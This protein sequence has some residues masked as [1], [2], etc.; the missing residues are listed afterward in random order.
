MFS[1]RQQ[2]T[3]LDATN[4]AVDKSESATR[5]EDGSEQHEKRG[6]TFQREQGGA[7]DGLWLYMSGVQFVTA[8]GHHHGVGPVGFF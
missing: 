1:H 3:G 7:V 4:S 2:L 5:T 8:P 6:R